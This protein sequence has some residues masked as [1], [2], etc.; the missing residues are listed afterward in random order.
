[1]KYYYLH[2]GFTSHILEAFIHFM[3]KCSHYIVREDQNNL[4]AELREF[5]HRFQ[6]GYTERNQLL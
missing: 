5:L 6:V 2:L 3:I 4:H 1:M